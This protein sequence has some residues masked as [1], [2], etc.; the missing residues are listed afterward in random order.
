MSNQFNERRNQKFTYFYLDLYRVE[1]N[2]KL[3]LH[4]VKKKCSLFVIIGTKVTEF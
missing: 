1:F 2:L 3:N 4:K